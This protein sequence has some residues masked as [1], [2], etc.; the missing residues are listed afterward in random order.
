MFPRTLSTKNK[1][2]WYWG[3]ILRTGGGNVYQNHFLVPHGD[4][5]SF[6]AECLQTVIHKY[7]YNFG[8]FPDLL[9]EEK[10]KLPV[11]TN[12]TLDWTHIG[13]YMRL[14]RESAETD[15]TATQSTL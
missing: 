10:I 13:E 9:K 11:I 5:G 7:L 12:G 4:G 6:E 8:L 3:G 1:S 15:L 2:I 14:K